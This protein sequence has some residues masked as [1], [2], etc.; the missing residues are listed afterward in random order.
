MNFNL[1][2]NNQ[3]YGRKDGDFHQIVQLTD[4]LIKIG[5]Y[6]RIRQHPIKGRIIGDTTNPD[7]FISQNLLV[8]ELPRNSFLKNHIDSIKSED[9]NYLA[10]G[11]DNSE[12]VYYIKNAESILPIDV[13]IVSHRSKIIKRQRLRPEFLA[14]Y[15][16]RLNPD[17]FQ[18]TQGSSQLDQNDF[19]LTEANKELTTKCV[20]ELVRGLDSMEF[21]PMD[22][23]GLARVF[24][25]FGVN[26]RY[27]G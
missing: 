13:E 14:Q 21:L 3:V 20:H 15:K 12:K 26:L 19:E 8:Y 16:K 18:E 27:L 24:H 23:P 25:Q 7:I 9:D 22:S 10:I 4:S 6:L 2:S 1:G 17:T 5:K 11:E